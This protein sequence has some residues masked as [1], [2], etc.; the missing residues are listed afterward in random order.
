MAVDP[1]VEEVRA[2]LPDYAPEYVQTLLLRSEYGNVERVVEALLEGTAPPPE[3]IQQQATLK[4]AQTPQ[5]PE[6]F[7]YTHDRRNV[8]DGEDMDTSRM[9][10]GK[11]RFLLVLLFLSTNMLNDGRSGGAWA[12][13]TRRRYS[14]TAHSWSK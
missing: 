5:A 14:R 8:F 11:K 10:I 1:R 7:E 12:V 2:I 6:A 13:T 4:K 9:R 3:A